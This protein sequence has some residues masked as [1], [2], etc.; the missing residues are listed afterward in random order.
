MY[1]FFGEKKFFVSFLFQAH[2]IYKVYFCYRCL[3][4]AFFGQNLIILFF[5]IWIFFWHWV[6]FC[7]WQPVIHL[8]WKNEHSQH[9]GINVWKSQNMGKIE[10]FKTVDR[11][12]VMFDGS[13]VGI[14]R[15]FRPHFAHRPGSRPHSVTHNPNPDCPRRV[16]CFFLTQR[17]PRGPG[18]N[19]WC[20]T[21]P[22]RNPSQACRQPKWWMGR[23]ILGV[24]RGFN[25]VF[26][27]LVFY[28]Y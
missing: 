1:S 20:P 12:R 23:R 21:K 10:E 19:G 25:F 6:F 27:L 22:S 2:E 5:V 8:E 7:F 15:K 14:V 26:V 11:V 17:Q 18:P 9:N 4:F 3:G 28:L 13:Q 24:S 16:R